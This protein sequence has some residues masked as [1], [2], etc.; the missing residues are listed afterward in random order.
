MDVHLLRQLLDAEDIDPAAYRLCEEPQDD[1]YV[2]AHPGEWEVY[3]AERGLR[4]GLERFG[5]EHDACTRLLELLLRDRTTR[6]GK[7]RPI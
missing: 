1:A 2:L 6:R 7:Q 5:N 4:I 3:F